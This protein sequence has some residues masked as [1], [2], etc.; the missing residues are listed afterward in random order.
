[1][2]Q[3]GPIGSDMLTT[4]R[5]P[6]VGSGRWKPWQTPGHTWQEDESLEGRTRKNMISLKEAAWNRFCSA[7]SHGISSAGRGCDPDQSTKNQRWGVQPPD[8]EQT[9]LPR[10]SFASFVCLCLTH[11]RPFLTYFLAPQNRPRETAPRNPKLL[12]PA[13]T[14]AHTLPRKPE[15][16]DLRMKP[17]KQWTNQQFNRGR[18]TQNKA[19]LELGP[20]YQRTVPTHCTSS[21]PSHSPF[22][23][24]SLL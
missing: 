17:S 13:L 11:P 2:V 1:M 16:L 9:G 14:A 22:Q 5:L 3:F 20:P 7:F 4:R 19:H 15:T 24:A 8:H 12:S 21:P 10:D 6:E 23:E 18:T